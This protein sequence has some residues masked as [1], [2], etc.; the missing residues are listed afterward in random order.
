MHGP[1]HGDYLAFKVLT[2]PGVFVISPLLI[3]ERTPLHELQ[4]EEVAGANSKCRS[5]PGSIEPER[6]PIIRPSRGVWMLDSQSLLAITNR[7][8]LL[9]KKRIRS[10]NS[11]TTSDSP[12]E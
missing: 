7:E 12:E 8:E 5:R 10:E 3:V 4:E 2:V 1:L 9:D 11:K 6:L